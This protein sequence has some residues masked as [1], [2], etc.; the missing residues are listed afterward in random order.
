MSLVTYARQR[1][2]I[3]RRGP[4]QTTVSP[5]EV[6]QGGSLVACSKPVDGSENFAVERTQVS[7]QIHI[8]IHIDF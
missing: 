7:A 6:K 2:T 4:R 1:N 5:A 8:H 3:V